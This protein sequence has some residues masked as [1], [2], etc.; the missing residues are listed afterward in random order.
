MEVS[1]DKWGIDILYSGTQKCLSCPPGISPV[2]VSDAAVET[3]KTRKTKV[4]NWYLDLTLIIN[5]WEGVKRAYHHT[6]PINMIY[7]FYQSL[8]NLLGEGLENSF[9]RHML[10][11]RKLVTG[12]EDLGLKLF[13]NPSCRLPMLNSVVVPDGVNEAGV[14]SRLRS[15]HRIE[16]GA[17]LG[18]MVGK[19]WRIG[20]MGETSKPEYVDR[21]L[22]ALVAV[23]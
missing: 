20:L 11:H 9:G 22:V 8:Y 7:A 10:N 16:I 1:V 14:R 5:Y 18:P 13:V 21:L 4:P 3:L 17:G 2:T 23:L 19:V 15:E 6:A 12:L